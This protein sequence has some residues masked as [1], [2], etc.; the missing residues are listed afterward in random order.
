MAPMAADAQGNVWTGSSDTANTELR[1]TTPQGSSA[2]SIPLDASVGGSV[3]VLAD[4][5]V[6]VSEWDVLRR[7]APDGTSRWAAP[8]R[9]AGIGLTPLVLAGGDAQLVVPTRA[10]TIHAVSAT[11][12]ELWRATLASEQELREASI[13]ARGAG[14]ST[15]YL[16]SRDGK[17]HAVIVDGA[18]DAAAP[19]PKAFHDPQNTSNAGSGL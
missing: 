6:A 19:W 17:L 12:A 18:L 2:R 1:L 11:G 14:T 4:G 8:P 7:F 15:A 9:L 16:T 5:D 13:A 3:V 10:G